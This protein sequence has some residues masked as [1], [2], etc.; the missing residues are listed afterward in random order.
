MVL[1]QCWQRKEW[2]LQLSRGTC[3]LL[4]WPWWKIL[5]SW[6]L[7]GVV[8][9]PRSDKR[10]REDGTKDLILNQILCV[11][12]I[13]TIACCSTELLMLKFLIPLWAQTCFLWSKLFSVLQLLHVWNGFS[14]KVIGRSPVTYTAFLDE[15]REKTGT[16]VQKNQLNVFPVCW[17]APEKPWPVPLN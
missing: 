4:T 11:A 13:T 12:V 1:W 7:F 2:S 16:E 5:P 14:N 9:R 3:L 17:N 15:W 10:Y 8:P 6:C